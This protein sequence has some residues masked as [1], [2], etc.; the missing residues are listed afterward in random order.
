LLTAHALRPCSTSQAERDE[1]SVISSADDDE[2]AFASLS[3]T[4]SFFMSVVSVSCLIPDNLELIKILRLDIT[5]SRIEIRL[6]CQNFHPY[7]TTVITVLSRL[8]VIARNSAVISPS[9]I[10]CQASWFTKE[11]SRASH[12]YTLGCEDDQGDIPYP[13][14]LRYWALLSYPFCHYFYLHQDIYAD[15]HRS[16]SQAPSFTMPGASGHTDTSSVNTVR[17]I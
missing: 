7:Q 4:I 16:D 12:V 3:T 2:T 11:V 10:R 9:P 1:R 17:S 15:M 14:P 6:A 8:Y 5:P 13:R